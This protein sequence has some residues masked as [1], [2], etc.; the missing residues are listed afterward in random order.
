M[1]G[2]VLG[3]IA[4]GGGETDSSVEAM[5]GLRLQRLGGGSSGWAV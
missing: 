4:Q 1:S 5:T 3:K 2:G